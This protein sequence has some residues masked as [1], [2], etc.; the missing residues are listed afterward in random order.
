MLTVLALSCVLLQVA[1]CEAK[2]VGVLGGM[3]K[4]GYTSV[5]REGAGTDG[6]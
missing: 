1:C 3:M 6:R 4:V 2:R 5:R